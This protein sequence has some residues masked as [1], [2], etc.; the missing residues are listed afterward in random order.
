MIEELADDV[1]TMPL[2]PVLWK[3]LNDPALEIRRA[4]CNLEIRLDRA[5]IRALW[6]CLDDGELNRAESAIYL[7]RRAGQRG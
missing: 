1:G 4:V 5:T 6:D 3:A 2:K 7:L